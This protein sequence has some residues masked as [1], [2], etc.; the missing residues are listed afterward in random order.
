V[1]IARRAHRFLAQLDPPDYP[2]VR[3]AV[4][5]L[6]ENPLPPGAVKLSGRKGWRIRVGDYRILYVIDSEADTVTVLDIGHRKDI[7]R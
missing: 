3:D 2:R 6:G 7:Y 4:R 1:L 5:Q